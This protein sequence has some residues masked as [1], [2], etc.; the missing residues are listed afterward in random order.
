MKRRARIL[1]NSILFITAAACGL[2]S[3][4]YLDPVDDANVRITTN[5][6]VTVYSLPR[7]IDWLTLDYTDNRI[8][9][10]TSSDL[11]TYHTYFQIFYRIYLSNVLIS[12][13]ISEI[14]LPV[15]NPTLASDYASLKPY[16]VKTNNYAASVGS[17]FASRSYWT[18]DD[19]SGPNILRSSGLITPYPSDRFFV[20]AADLKNPAYLNPNN[21]A[22]VVTNSEGTAY[23]YVSQY[24]VNT[25]LNS[26]T[27][28]L[29]YSAPTFLGVYLLPNPAYYENVVFSNLEI[30]P[31]SGAT[32]ALIITLGREIPGL[33]VDDIIIN[34]SSPPTGIQ[35]AGLSNIGA[36]YTLTV[37]SISA[38][39][40]ITVSPQ[41]D[42]FNFQPATRNIAVT[43]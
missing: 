39:G 20:N 8:P 1:L 18:I 2:D 5:T 29:N 35:K 26:T 34:D 7:G 11:N 36:V 19:A 23:A 22:D 43:P 37:N 9:R 21:N 38:V 12:S 4:G 16:T 10:I 33:T 32:S 14:N 42:G 25:E 15:I 27:L 3:I 40:T 41:K 31:A 24:I 30:S 6:S 17:A 13:T 28:A